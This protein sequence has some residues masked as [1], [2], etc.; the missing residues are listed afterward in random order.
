[1]SCSNYPL[2]RARSRPTRSKGDTIKQRSNPCKTSLVVELE[3]TPAPKKQ[4]GQQHREPQMRLD[5]SLSPLAA[6]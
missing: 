5:L 2:A 4:P 3:R 1:M 6:L